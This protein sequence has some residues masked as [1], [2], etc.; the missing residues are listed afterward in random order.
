M[1]LS[2]LVFYFFC[3]Q[4]TDF[5]ARLTWDEIPALP[6]FGSVRATDPHCWIR[7]IQLKSPQLSF[8]ICEMR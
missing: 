4:K 3:G 7:T 8:L 5:G 2:A 6:P 1:Y